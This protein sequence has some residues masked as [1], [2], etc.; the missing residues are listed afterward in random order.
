MVIVSETGGRRGYVFVW[1]AGG[2]LEETTRGQGFRLRFRERTGSC[3]P[4][5][6]RG[7]SSEWTPLP[8]VPRDRGHDLHKSVPLSRDSVPDVFG[9][10]APGPPRTKNISTVS[11][12]GVNRVTKSRVGFGTPTIPR[13]PRPPTTPT[14]EVPPSPGPRGSWKRSREGRRQ[15]GFCAPSGVGSWDGQ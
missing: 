4:R 5:G 3:G 13:T 9:C 12:T 15:S 1:E 2:R 8:L 10:R 7:L 11:D 6:D 14:P